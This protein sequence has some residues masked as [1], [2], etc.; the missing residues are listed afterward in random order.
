MNRLPIPAAIQPNNLK[1]RA[2]FSNSLINLIPMVSLLLL[3][4]LTTGTHFYTRYSLCAL[5]YVEGIR[6][7]EEWNGI[8]QHFATSCDFDFLA[9]FFF[10]YVIQKNSKTFPF[11]IVCHICGWLNLLLNSEL[12]QIKKWVKR[13]FSSY[14]C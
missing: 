8:P 3:R 7:F 13:S 1:H 5:F 11:L 12:I 14:C 10:L 6:T 9:T 4:G 2:Y